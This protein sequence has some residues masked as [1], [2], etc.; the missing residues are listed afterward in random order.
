M[1]QFLILI[2]AAFNLFLKAFTSGISEHHLQK[3]SRVLSFHSC[4]LS[5]CPTETP[6]CCCGNLG[7]ANTHR[8]YQDWG[9]SSTFYQSTMR[10][11]CLPYP[12]IRKDPSLFSHRPCLLARRGL[13]WR[14]FF[15]S[16]KLNTDATKKS[17]VWGLSSAS[18]YLL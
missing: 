18:F 17:Q 15:L 16:A 2:D 12:V 6:C 14:I 8:K 10:N 7:M 3:M 11:G 13:S 4:V 1:H 9:L 5:S